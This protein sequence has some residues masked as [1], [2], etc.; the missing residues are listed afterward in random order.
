MGRSGGP[1]R[2]ILRQLRTSE[3]PQAV[4]TIQDAL[5]LHG[6]FWAE[7]RSYGLPE[8]PCNKL[9]PHLLSSLLNSSLPHC[10]CAAIISA[11][12]QI[13]LYDLSKILAVVPDE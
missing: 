5:D 6:H 3:R 9:P 1:L 12:C 4:A 13:A 10:Q 8:I 11:R 2:T 7:L